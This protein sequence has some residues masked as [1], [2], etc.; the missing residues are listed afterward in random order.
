MFNIGGCNGTFT[1]ALEEFVAL[2]GHK[3]GQATH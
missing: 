2:V 1:K 3:E